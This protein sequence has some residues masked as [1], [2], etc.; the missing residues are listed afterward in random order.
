M[1]TKQQLETTNV[2]TFKKK[3]E[4]G[5]QQTKSLLRNYV[6]DEVCE[7]SEASAIREVFG[8]RDAVYIEGDL[9]D[10]SFGDSVPVRRWMRYRNVGWAER[11]DPFA[12]LDSGIDPFGP[13]AQL[14]VAAMHRIQDEVILRGM[15]GTNRKGK[16]GDEIDDFD[17]NHIIRMTDTEDTFFQTLIGQLIK[18][19]AWWME[20]DVSVD[21]ERLVVGLPADVWMRLFA[22]D[23][24]TS[25]DYVNSASL[26]A[27]KIDS[28]AGFTF[29][30]IERV[31]GKSKFPN[32]IKFPRLRDGVQYVLPCWCASGVAFAQRKNIVVKYGENPQKW[33]APQITA[34]AS[35]GAARVEPKKV[36][37]LEITKASLGLAKKAA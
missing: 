12:T 24:T 8:A 22:L 1:S 35:F 4:I 33:H 29:V 13:Y 26:Q 31:P 23:K 34:T 7:L 19:K 37:G 30:N 11:I 36:L 15:L 6:T 18:A 28:F 10:T 2:L 14:A 20:N 32:D 3:L 5:L 25:K 21:S 17:T 27:G 9:E 16:L